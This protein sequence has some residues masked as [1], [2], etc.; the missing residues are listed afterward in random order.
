MKMALLFFSSCRRELALAFLVVLAS[1][2]SASGQKKIACPDGEHIE[3][4]VRQISIQYDASSFAGTLSSLSVLGARLEVKPT[5]L[6]EAA[7]ATQQWDEFL[8]G[9]AAG[10]NSCAITRQQYADGV[11][12]IYP[13]LKEDGAQLEEMR[14][15]IA[16]GQKA[17]SKRLQQLIDSFDGNLRQFAH[18]SGREIILERIAALSEQVTSSTQQEQTH[19]EVLLDKLNEIENTNKQAPLPT[20]EQVG[21]QIS[22]VRKSLLAKADEAETAYNKGYALLDQYR[23]A[24]AIPYLQ[25]AL[26]EVRLPDFY[27]ALGEAYSDLGNLNQAEAVLREGL[28]TSTKDE[29]KEALLESQL[30]SVLYAKGDVDGAMEYTQRALQINQKVYGPDHPTVSID[31]NNIGSILMAKGDLDGALEYTQRALKI[32]ENVYGSDH[33]IVALCAN[34]IGEILKAKGDLDGAMPYVQRALKIDEKVYGPDHPEVAIRANN[35]GQILQ[36]KGE[37]AGALQYTQAALAIFE[38]VYGTNHPLT[39]ATAVNLERI[40][41]WMHQ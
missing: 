33:P 38:K 34:N 31:A 20:P 21:Q 41:K 18:V 3:I 23:F 4:D 30:G 17:D 28:K 9:L 14:K 22:E 12:R 25:Q 16:A 13:R 37:L 26:S 7:V 10:Y 35:I 32:D 2:T 40:R 29:Q 5:K 24:E 15:M 11:T 39:K 19:F 1:A 36:D 6:Q 8:K 27:L